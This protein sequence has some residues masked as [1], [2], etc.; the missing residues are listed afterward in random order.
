MLSLITFMLLLIANILFISFLFT[1]LS[2][3]SVNRTR[4]RLAQTETL[5]HDLKCH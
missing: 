2:P 1:T 4:V 3:V 5:L